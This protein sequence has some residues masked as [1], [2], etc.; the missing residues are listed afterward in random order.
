MHARGRQ[1]TNRGRGKM[2]GGKKVFLQ[3][4]LGRGLAD[5]VKTVLTVATLIAGTKYWPGEGRIKE[6]ILGEGAFG[7]V[8]ATNSS[9]RRRAFGNSLAR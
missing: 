9:M 2:S 1:G 3:A 6:N 8:W 5:F 7:G 4:L